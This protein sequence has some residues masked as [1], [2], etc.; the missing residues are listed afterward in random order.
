MLPRTVFLLPL[1]LTPGKHDITVR[2]PAAAGLVQSWRDLEAPVQ[3][4][5]P[6]A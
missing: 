6:D 2:F 5:A 4:E 1:K 3:G